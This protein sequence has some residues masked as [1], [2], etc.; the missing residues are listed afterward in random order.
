MRAHLRRDFG[1][2][3]S[4]LCYSSLRITAYQCRIPFLLIGSLFRACGELQSLPDRGR[5]VCQPCDD[6]CH[7]ERILVAGPLLIFDGRKTLFFEFS[8]RSGP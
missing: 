3:D 8:R 6:A 1:C 7:T 5:R 4:V 2:L